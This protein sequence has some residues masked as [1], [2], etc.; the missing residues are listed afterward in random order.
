[1]ITPLLHASA[2]TKLYGMRPVLRGVDLQ[3]DRGEFVT[4]LGPNGA[5]KTTLLRILATLNRPN[6]GTL[7]IGGVDALTHAAHARTAIGVVSHHTLVYPDLT[8]YENLRF[9]GQMQGM[10]TRRDLPARIEAVLRRVNLWSRAHDFARTF[11]R[12]ML[13]RLSIARAILHDPALLLM[14]EPYTGLDQTSAQALSELLHDVAVS[15]RAVVMTTHE[16][17]RGLEHVTR[18]THI[19]QGKLVEGRP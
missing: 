4:V 17:S 14:D 8:P 18:Y 12:G 11:S 13:Q 16:L 15:G 6:G 7:N 1:M 2:L 3:V 9:A 10:D 5:G 19:A